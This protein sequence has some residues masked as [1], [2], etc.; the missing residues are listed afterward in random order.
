MFRRYY[1]MKTISRKAVIFLAAL[2]IALAIVGTRML[3][4]YLNRAAWERAADVVYPMANQHIDWT[5]A[6]KGGAGR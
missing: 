5:Y 2:V 3:D 6:G 4:D 1:T